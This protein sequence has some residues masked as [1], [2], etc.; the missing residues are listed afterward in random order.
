[1]ETA[2]DLANAISLLH[3]RAP[4]TTAYPEVCDVTEISEIMPIFDR[5][6]VQNIPLFVVGGL[7]RSRMYIG[8]T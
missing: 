2:T 4:V 3:D 8:E 6:Q 5:Y 7:Y 1:M